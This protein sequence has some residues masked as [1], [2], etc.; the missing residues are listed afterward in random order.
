MREFQQPKSALKLLAPLEADN[1][2]AA[3]NALAAAYAADQQYAKAVNVAEDACK[4]APEARRK[5]CLERLALYR[6]GQ[7]YSTSGGPVHP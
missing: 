4:K 6:L 3:A 1:K 5:T 7:A 2:P